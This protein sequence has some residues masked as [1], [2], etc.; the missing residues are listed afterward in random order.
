MIEPTDWPGAWPCEGRRHS[1]Q[2]DALL[3][4][5]RSL[6]DLVERHP[7]ALLPVWLVAKLVNFRDVVRRYDALPRRDQA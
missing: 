7:D 4:E 3:C 5:A 1:I 2:M 6:S